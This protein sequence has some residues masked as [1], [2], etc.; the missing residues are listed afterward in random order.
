MLLALI[1]SFMW[2]FDYP[3]EELQVKETARQSQRPS[4][5]EQNP[6]TSPEMPQQPQD[7]HT[8]SSEGGQIIVRNRTTLPHEGLHNPVS[9]ADA[10]KTRG[11]RRSIKQEPLYSRFWAHSTRNKEL[12][13]DRNRLAGEYKSLKRDYCRL[14][15]EHE[16]IIV[17]LR[18][19]QRTCK[20]QQQE[21]DLLREKLRGASALLDVRNQELNVAKTFLSKEDTFSASDVVQSV[22][23]L[24]SE[25]MQAAAYLAES[26]P[27]KRLRT[28]SAEE[29]P[30]GPCKST[31]VTLFLPP[32]PGDGIDVGSVELALQNFL[33][34]CA[35]AVA[36]TWGLGKEAGWCAL[37]YSMVCETGT[38]NPT[39]SPRDGI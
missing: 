35:A 11:E 9:G 13:N 36:N 22:R 24:N 25:I 32:G 5:D 1:Q 10:H 23:D 7:N 14:S 30:E 12:E 31:F 27:L 37:L 21:I 39:I 29:I 2:I 20:G 6:S 18:E 16:S 28:P 26:L 33:A 34:W 3:T 38:I 17:N 15:E 8:N 19:S 4:S